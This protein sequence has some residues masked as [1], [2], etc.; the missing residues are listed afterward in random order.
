MVAIASAVH[1]DQTRKLLNQG[2][3]DCVPRY[4]YLASVITDTIEMIASSTPPAF[5]FNA[6]S[7]CPF[8]TSA[9]EVVIPHAGQGIPNKNLI[10]QGGSPNC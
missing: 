6:S 10:V 8:N 3:I 9:Q 2:L 5:A 1:N 4:A 7:G